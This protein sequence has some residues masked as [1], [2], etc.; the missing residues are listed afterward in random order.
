MKDNKLLAIAFSDL[1]INL[2]AKF[3]SDRK[4]T[5]DN[6]RVLSV[7]RDLCKAHK[8]PALFCGDLFQKGEVIEN[9]LF[10]MASERFREL[11][12]E[13]DCFAI[14]GNHDMSKANTLEQASPSFVKSMSRMVPWLQCIDLIKYP[15]IIKKEIKAWVYGVPYIDHNVGLNQYLKNLE[16]S[17]KYHNIL[18]LHTDYPGA[19][20]TDGRKID[21][22]ENLNLNTL[23]RFDLVLCGH[24][25]KPQKLSKKVYMIGAP[26]QMRRTDRGC[27]MGYWKIYRDLRMEFVE[28][29]DFPKFID[30]ESP[31]EIKDDGNYYTVMPKK[32][33]K[34]KEQANKIH[35]NLS[36][37]SLARQYIKAKGIKDKHKLKLLKE[38]LKKSSKDD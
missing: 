3:N 24:I 4:R 2:W 23:K 8:V 16:I 1:H 37:S 10:E 13:W 17:D 28:L 33:E 34:P 27:K 31:E 22:V 5:L 9:E 35:R 20:D 18:M 6:F 32:E 11:G 14:S 38:V 15:I 19:K 7:I 36:K 26:H 30:V 25:H 29:K 21:S 12:N